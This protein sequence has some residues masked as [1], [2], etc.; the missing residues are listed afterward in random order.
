MKL[1]ISNIA[2]SEAH[3]EEMYDFLSKA[4]FEGIEIAPTRIFGEDPY[5]K[6]AE[7]R[8]FHK[9]LEEVYHLEI[10]SIQS[11]WYGRNENI[12]SSAAERTSLLEYTQ[13]AF[14]FA[15]ELGC[16]NLVFGCPRN[17]NIDSAGDRNIAVEF[18]RYLGE[19]AEQQNTVLALEANPVIYSTNFLNYTDETYEFVKMVDSSGIKLNYDLGT[20]IENRESVG[21]LSEMI[22]KVNHVHI[23]EPYLAQVNYTVMHKE[24]VEVLRENNYSKYVSIEM[25]NMDDLSMVKERIKQ[26]S[27][28]VRKQEYEC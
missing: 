10:S 2:W 11:I 9:M 28:L 8:T 4:G 16:K 18:F 17:R 15:H 6:L 21:Q 3:D 24:L 1:S 12:F 7:A 25:K 26:L 14:I 5:S 13:R 20:V 19:L 23:S 27:S 22:D